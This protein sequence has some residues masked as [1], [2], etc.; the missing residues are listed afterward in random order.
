MY[1][2][3]IPGGAATL[4]RFAPRK[5]DLALTQKLVFRYQ[6]GLD[7]ALR[8]VGTDEY[9]ELCALM[10]AGKGRDTRREQMRGRIVAALEE[11]FDQ[12]TQRTIVHD[13]L[14]GQGD[15]SDSA[16]ILR[17]IRSEYRFFSNVRHIL[18]TYRKMGGWDEFACR[19]V[20][21]DLSLIHISSSF[22]R[23]PAGPHG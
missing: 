23:Q 6:A 18:S 17:P 14:A 4:L 19:C 16:A 1:K 22:G 20:V 10:P 3:Q 12:G 9:A 13:Y 11:I 2:R 15:F 21:L 8:Y 5:L 7:E